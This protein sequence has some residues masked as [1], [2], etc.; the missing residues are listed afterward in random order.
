MLHTMD[1]TN[2]PYIKHLLHPM[3]T[4]IPSFLKTSH[5]LD[6]WRARPRV[7]PA[8]TDEYN[9]SNITIHQSR[10]ICKDKANFTVI[11]QFLA[12]CNSYPPMAAHLF[13]SYNKL[14]FSHMF[15]VSSFQSIK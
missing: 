7:G 12:G 13:L 4:S 9:Y 10:G 14:Q 3:P 1:N 6:L 8:R 5:G 11:I 2:F 15:T